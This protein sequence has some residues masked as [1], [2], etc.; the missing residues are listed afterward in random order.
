MGQCSEILC[1]IRKGI[2]GSGRSRLRLGLGKLLA[3]GAATLLVA[4][5]IGMFGLYLRLTQGP[6]GVSFLNSRIEAAIATALPEMR[7]KLG[8]AS[9]AIDPKT[10]VP[11]LAFDNITVRDA[12][13]NLIANAPHAAITLNRGELLSGTISPKSLELIG[14]HISA[15]RNLDGT[16]V[17]G[18]NAPQDPTAAP[19]QVASES[20]KPGAETAT[21]AKE[22]SGTTLLS[23][24]D[25]HDTTNTISSLEDIRISDAVINFYDDGNA[26]TWYAPKADLSFQKKPYGFVILAK[27]DVA[28]N[29]KPWHAEMSATYR[30]DAK[31]FEVSSTL[32]NVIPATVAR[33]IFALSQFAALTTPLSG[34]VDFGIDANGTL[35]G[36]TGEF[37]AAAGRITL[38]DVFA[39]PIAI[40]EGALRIAYDPQAT[41]FT[42]ANS[43]LVV[44]GRRIDLSGEIKPL[45]GEDG[46]LS[47]LAIKL[48]TRNGAGEIGKTPNALVDRIEFT[49]Q[50]SVDKA[51][52]EIEDLV[53][54]SGNT[55][56][57]MR[58]NITGGEKSPGIHLAGR[59]RDISN[60]LM[61]LLWP[62]IVAPRSRAWINENVSSGT[63]PEGTFQINFDE[64]ALAA[65]KETHHN[66]QG[67]L[68]FQFSMNNVTTHYFKSLPDLQKASGQAHLQDNSFNLDI[69]HGFAKLDSGETIKLNSGSFEA[70][71]LQVETIV[72]LFK[73]DLEA[74]IAA[75]LAVAT[76]PDLKLIKADSLS[77]LPDASGL[78][79]VKLELQMPLEKDPPKDQ[80]L[81]KTEV[82]VSDVAIANLAPGVDLTGGA[83]NISVNQ[84]KIDIS[85]P[86]K[87]NGQASEITWSKPREGGIATARFT[88]TLDDKSREK[89]GLKLAD[90]L[91]G[92]VAVDATMNKDQNGTYVFDVKADLSEAAMHLSTLSWSR[93]PTPGT[94][95]SFH[96]VST[97]QG[98]SI[99]NFKLDGDGLHLKGAIEL[100]KDGKLKAVSMNEIKLDEDN[101]FSVRAIP[102][103]GTTDL[104]ITGTNLDARP[105]IKAVL[106]PAPKSATSAATKGN[107]QD[108]TMRAHFDK[109]IANRGEILKDVSATLRAR[110]GRIAEANIQ[111]NFINDQPITATV[112]PLPQ[113][114]EMRVKSNDAGST[115]RAANFY[116]KIAGGA[117]SFSALIG[118]EDGS[119]MRN[120]NLTINNFEVRNETTLADLDKRGKSQKSGPRSEAVYFSTLTLPFSADEKFIRFK[121]GNVR[122]PTMCATADGVIRKV[123]NAL[124]ISGTVIPACG[125]SRALNNVPVIGDILSGG[126]YNEGIFGVT[127]AMGGTFANPQIQMN[128]ISALAPGI[129]R[130]LFDFNPK[131]PALDPAAKQ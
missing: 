25:Q 79:H 1:C 89:L 101:I 20:T 42:I 107:N 104:T 21:E 91:T 27:A 31:K 61:K 100:F 48:A 84:E 80:V 116:S 131:Q 87:I 81:L 74:P 17:L 44:G 64:N 106:S 57:R 59:V 45:R 117:I 19:S 97:D 13:G 76:N 41:A 99:Q 124:D 121:D 110:G 40:D 38:P 11:H 62:P 77:N 90:Y 39:D 67:S 33:K 75:M 54:M 28:T 86:A 105:Y 109:V 47:A 49:G 55:G 53:I 69:D 23:L 3:I 12:N 112:V 82:N 118:N 88:T 37:Q 94:T 51:R 32:D 43:T 15:R 5:C 4:A 92:P 111:G 63:I 24:L 128:P 35:L 26:A 129:F 115:L 29:A 125:L 8:D 102:S 130:R 122:G 10:N 73:F 119:P 60:E 127:Y 83:F 103:D 22:T 18:F 66:P 72:G 108:F 36:G 98:R 113:G 78:G 46:K 126:N 30:H 58:G 9:L 14:A 93:P 6:M 120:G 114:R 65:A 68:D 85:G 123:D 95:S 70:N 52:L 2:L 96:V 34:H 7:V 71:D 50:A 56:L 16:L